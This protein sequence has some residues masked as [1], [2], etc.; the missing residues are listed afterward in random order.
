MKK[1]NTSYRLNQIMEE[2]NLKQVDILNL[3]E[4]YCK[5]YNVKLRRNDLSQYVSGKVEPGQYKLFVLSK[6]LGVSEAWLMGYDVPA[7]PKKGKS[8]N[9]GSV[10]PDIWNKYM[11]LNENGQRKADEYI[12]DLHGNTKYRK[13]T[14]EKFNAELFEND[15]DKVEIAAYGGHGVSRQD[16]PSDEALKEAE[17]YFQ[18]K[19][20]K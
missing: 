8:D 5:K 10:V 19:N 12:S 15:N 13:V 9:I 1:Y 20:R 6:A 11:D 4:P 7:T 2:R 14:E 3:S 17:K 18:E 16:A